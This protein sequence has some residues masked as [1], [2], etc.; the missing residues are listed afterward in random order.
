MLPSKL[1]ASKQ[2]LTE[3]LGS[4]EKADVTVVQED[5]ALSL[6]AAEL[7]SFSRMVLALQA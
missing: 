1:P 3:M 7:G 4:R 5:Q 2:L 6:G